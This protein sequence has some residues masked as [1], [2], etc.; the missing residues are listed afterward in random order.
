[1]DSSQKSAASNPAGPG[2]EELKS[3]GVVENSGAPHEKTGTENN[4]S[5]QPNRK[6]PRDPEEYVRYGFKGD[7]VGVG[8]KTTPSL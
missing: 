4:P 8:N 2:T 5:S 7:G 1:M 6:G 3:E